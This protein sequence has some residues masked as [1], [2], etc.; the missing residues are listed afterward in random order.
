M[1]ASVDSEPA[2]VR[3][4]HSKIDEELYTRM[5]VYRNFELM[6]FSEISGNTYIFLFSMFGI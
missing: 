6:F 5:L 4:N 3:K 2:E 1:I